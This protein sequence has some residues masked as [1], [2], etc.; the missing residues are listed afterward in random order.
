MS[1]AI[2][3]QGTL[4]QRGDGATSPEGFTTIGEITGFTGPG[5]EATEIDVTH[6]G[7]TAKEFLMGLKD[8][9][10]VTLDMN[11]I[12]SD[13]QQQGLQTDRTN[14]TLRSFRIFVPDSASPANYIYFTA[15]VQGFSISAAPDSKYE[16]SVTLRVSGAVTWPS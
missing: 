5:G 15:F 14:Q 2:K 9:G 6:L 3:T 7:S 13:A 8:E 11:Y 4:F 10:T 12:V 16:G 1:S